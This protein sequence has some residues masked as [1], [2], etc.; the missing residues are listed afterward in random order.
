MSR[1]HAIYHVR[2]A[3]ADVAARAA[4]LALEQSI[5]M[6][7]APVTSDY[8][9]DEIVARVEGCAQI[10]PGV[11]AVTLALATAT[12]GGEIG[13]AMNM[14]FGNCSLQDDVTLVD[15]ALPDDFLAGFRGPRYGLDGMREA[16]GAGSRALT[17][18]ALKPQGLPS[19]ELAALCETFAGAGLD[20]VKDDH[21]ITNQAYSPFAARVAACQAAVRRANAATGGR[22]VYAPSLSGGPRQLRE[23]VRIVHD[24]GVRMVLACP[25]L[26]GLACFAELVDELR[27]PVIAHPALG[28][29][30]RIAPPLLFGRLFRLLGADATIFPNYGGRFSFSRETC[31]ALAHAG[32]AAWRDFRACAPVPAGGMSVERVA[33]MIDV[34][35][36]DV[37]LLIGGNLLAAGTDLPARSR[38]FVDTVRRLSSAPQE[39]AR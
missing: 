25:M 34:Y 21:G 5:E 2:C 7:L 8:V 12:T 23:Q 3:A 18:T 36:R 24:E 27:C 4:A 32:R 33:E 38:H 39:S 15:V 17:M 19:A 26:M 28:G 30:S 29:A 6:P 11:H 9:R 13:Q 22:S 16:V 10:A 31:E 20:I 35:G 14:L 37:C 1:F